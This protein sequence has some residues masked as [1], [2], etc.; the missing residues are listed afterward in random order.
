[1]YNAASG[2]ETIDVQNL[3][4]GEIGFWSVCAI[5]SDNGCSDVNI[6]YDRSSD[7]WVFTY[8]AF[9]SPFNNNGGVLALGVSKDT[10]IADG[11]VIWGLGQETTG[12]YDAPRLGITSDKVVVS[13]NRYGSD[14]ANGS[15]CT[16]MFIIN[17]SQLYSLNGFNWQKYQGTGVN[18]QPVTVSGLKATTFSEAPDAAIGSTNEMVT[19][20]LSGP[21]GK[22]TWQTTTWTIGNDPWGPYEY[23]PQIYG[24]PPAPQPGSSVVLD[25]DANEFQSSVYGSGLWVVGNNDCSGA[26]CVVMIN[27]SAASSGVPT[28]ITTDYNYTGGSGSSVMYPAI[29]TLG[30]V[31]D[32]LGVL[33]YTC[34]SCGEYA[35]SDTFEVFIGGSFEGG[36]YEAGNVDVPGGSGFMGA[37]DARWG[38]INGCSFLVG[39]NQEAVCVGQFASSSSPPSQDNS[40]SEVYTFQAS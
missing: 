35:S 16:F 7:R 6:R 40:A 12:S 39:G 9:P 2:G 31:S 29:S 27:F 8:L 1:M 21:E 34:A 28:S 30:N 23:T 11:W 33:D 26:V 38:D 3:A 17:K 24:E 37:S 22:V 15:P 13:L 20:Y 18:Y 10:N 19:H 25:T 36:P 4:G 32:V 14:C 5:G